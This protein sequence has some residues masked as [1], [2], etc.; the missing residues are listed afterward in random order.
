[1]PEFVGDGEAALQDAWGKGFY[2]SWCCFD[3]S[4]HFQVSL[5]RLE[6]LPYGRNTTKT[7]Y[8]RRGRGKTLGSAV[9]AAMVDQFEDVLG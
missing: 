9:R 8:V 2:M 5:R 3:E 6:G 1:M 7:Y 4:Q